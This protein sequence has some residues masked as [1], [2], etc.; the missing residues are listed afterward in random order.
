MTH[1]DIFKG[2]NTRRTGR[3]QLLQRYDHT[4]V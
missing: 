3:W 2:I 4:A 1:K